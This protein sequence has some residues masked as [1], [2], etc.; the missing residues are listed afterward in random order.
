LPNYK[1]FTT[2]AQRKRRRQRILGEEKIGNAN[3]WEEISGCHSLLRF[4]K[5]LFSVFSVPLW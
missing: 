4:L 3:S 5:P 1:R 2:E